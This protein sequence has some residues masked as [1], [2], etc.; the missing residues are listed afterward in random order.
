[1]LPYKR[2]RGREALKKLRVFSGVPEKYKKTEEVPIDNIL[3]RTSR[4]V[5]VGEVSR[6]LGYE[7]RI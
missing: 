3:E 6:F 4:Y 7:V 1:M 2:A 5:R